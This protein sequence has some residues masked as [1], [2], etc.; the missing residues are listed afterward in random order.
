MAFLGEH[1]V[2]RSVGTGVSDGPTRLREG[3][4]VGY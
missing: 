2:K 3:E 1:L 4:V